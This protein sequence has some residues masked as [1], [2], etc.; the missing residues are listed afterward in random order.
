MTDTRKRLQRSE[1]QACVK[2][3]GQI[4]RIYKRL[5]RLISIPFS[6]LDLHSVFVAG[7]TMIYCVWL[8]STLYDADLASDFGTCSTVLYVMAEQWTSATKYRDAFENIAERTMEYAT[9]SSTR[10]SS[11]KAN[12]NKATSNGS[13]GAM[14][15]QGHNIMLIPQ[16]EYWN[17]NTTYC[18]EPSE[19]LDVWQ[20]MNDFAGCQN[21]A[22]NQLTELPGIEELLVDEGLG[23]FS[24]YTQEL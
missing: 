21:D 23:W 12:S 1:F 5:H 18:N 24:G 8:D 7:F 17:P 4:C 2:A 10:Q 13:S 6:L 20:M 15:P 11:N 9:S 16:A 22:D 14:H 3:S 19:T